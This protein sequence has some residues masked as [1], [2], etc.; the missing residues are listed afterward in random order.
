MLQKTLCIKMK[1][2]TTKSAKH[3]QEYRFTFV[4]FVLFVVEK[5]ASANLST[6]NLSIITLSKDTASCF[7]FRVFSVFRGSCFDRVDQSHHFSKGLFCSIQGLLQVLIAM[8]S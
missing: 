1:E 5:D 7:P 8:R 6:A 3:T 4:G 2:F